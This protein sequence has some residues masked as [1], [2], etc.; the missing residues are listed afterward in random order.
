MVIVIIIAL[1]GIGGFLMSWFLQQAVFI[2]N[3]MNMDMIAADAINLMIN[4]DTLA[5]GLRFS[6]RITLADNDQLD[7][8]NQDGYQVNYR[9]Q[10][11]Q[12]LIERRILDGPN[13]GGWLKIPYY[14]PSNVAFDTPGN[15]MFTYYNSSESTTSD[16][17]QVRR[18]SINLIAS[19]GTGSFSTWGSSVTRTSAV[20]TKRYQ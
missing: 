6:R 7:F 15:R 1:G 5:A 8:I 9:F 10:N 14:A 13:A 18:V 16:A 17:D 3:Q 12:D 4:G 2:P 11:S 19:I 20:T